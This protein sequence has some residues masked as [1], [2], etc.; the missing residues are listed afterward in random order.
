MIPETPN[1]ECTGRCKSWPWS[2]Q[3][4]HSPTYCDYKC[5]AWAPKQQWCCLHHSLCL[6]CP[7]RHYGQIHAAHANHWLLQS[8]SN[9]LKHSLTFSFEANPISNTRRKHHEFIVLLDIIKL[10]LAHQNCRCS[11]RDTETSKISKVQ[12]RELDRYEPCS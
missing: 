1:L 12:K 10:K 4:I 5:L 3:Q 2:L 9:S 6:K 11:L 7:M 8:M